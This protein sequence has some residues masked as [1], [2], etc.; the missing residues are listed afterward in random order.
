MVKTSILPLGLI[1]SFVLHTTETHQHMTWWSR[2]LLNNMVRHKR[3][4]YFPVCFFFILTTSSVEYS[5]AGCVCVC[6]CPWD[7]GTWDIWVLSPVSDHCHLLA[8]SSLLS[9]HGLPSFRPQS[10][11]NSRLSV[12]N[13]FKLL[14]HSTSNLEFNRNRCTIL[15]EFVNSLQL[16]KPINS[17]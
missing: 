13:F 4:A 14:L 2:N 7:K 11:F 15:V 8:V 12:H 16:S 5:A 3:C 9:L 10:T 6:V 17:I 1:P